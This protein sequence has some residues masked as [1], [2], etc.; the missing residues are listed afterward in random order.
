[1]IRRLPGLNEELCAQVMAVMDKNL[2]E[3]HIRGGQA[4]RRRYKNI[5]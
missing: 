1:M 5:H 2:S 3:R 4:T